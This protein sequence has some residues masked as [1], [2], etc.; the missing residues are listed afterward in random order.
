MAGCKLLSTNELI[1]QII[2]FLILLVLL[3]AFAWKKILGALDKRKEQIASGFQEIEEAKAD[4]ERMRLDYDAK[5]SSI[6]QAAKH[7]IHE[8]V[9]ESKVILE[10]ARKNAHIQAQ[11]IIDN[12]KSSIKYE[13]AKAKDDLKNEIIELTIKA[14]E[15]VIKEK[16]TEKGDRV[17]VQEFLDGVDKL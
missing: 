7:K 17:L 13:L 5:L 12:A 1:A 8:A 11:E 3:R 16:L 2:G 14:S 10:D 9:N 6:E 4:I 15:N